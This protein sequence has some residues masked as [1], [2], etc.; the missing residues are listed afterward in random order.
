MLE[1][2]DQEY[3]DAVRGKLLNAQI[4]AA[5][6]STNQI[7]SRETRM[8]WSKKDSSVFGDKDIMWRP[9]E[10]VFGPMDWLSDINQRP[11]VSLEFHPMARI[12]KDPDSSQSQS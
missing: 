10:M 1:I 12:A 3:D 4:P 11:K 5:V 7:E 8:F 2:F 6:N 9:T